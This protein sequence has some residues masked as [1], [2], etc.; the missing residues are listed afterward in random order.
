MSGGNPGR[1]EINLGKLE[2]PAESQKKHLFGKGKMTVEC[3]K[4]H[5][6]FLQERELL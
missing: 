3:L 4:R 2:R 6:P 1:Y 5:V